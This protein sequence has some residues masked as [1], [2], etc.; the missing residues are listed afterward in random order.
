MCPWSDNW[1]IEGDKAWFC[2][3]EVGALFCVDMNSCECELVSRIP[4]CQFAGF[5]LYSYCMKCADRVFCLPS[6][7]DCIWIYELE[8]KTWEKIGLDHKEQIFHY[9]KN[10]N[11]IFFWDFAGYLYRMDLDK[12]KVSTIFH[13]AFQSDEMTQYVIVDNKIYHVR[14]NRIISLDLCGDDIRAVTYEIPDL[15]A[16]LFAIGYDGAN[17]WLSGHAKEICIWHPES[18]VIKMLRNFPEQFGIYHFKVGETPY[19][20]C[21]TLVE[22]ES[23]FFEDSVSLGAYM[24]FIPGRSSDI[25][26]ISKETYEA[27]ILEIEEERET[28]ESIEKNYMGFKYILQYVR[29][30][31][32]IGVYSFKN[33]RV[34]EIDTVELTVTYRDYKLDHKSVLMIEKAAAGYHNGKILNERREK[35]RKLFSRLLEEK[36]ESSLDK[37]GHTGELIY[38]TLHI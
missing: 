23:A 14:D 11:Q 28:K 38:H 10:S 24:W 16:G 25:I 26:Y 21:K 5:R 20:D 8:E 9:Q 31:R 3:G 13:E 1:W 36:N 17:F 18:G 33:H 34:F 6:M 15:K 30:D 27:F 22:A 37:Y 4:E 2:G 7:G 29:E 35:D 32:Y 12:K 19:L